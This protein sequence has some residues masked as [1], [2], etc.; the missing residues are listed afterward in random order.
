M[1]ALVLTVGVGRDVER[2]LAHSIRETN[3]EIVVFIHSSDSLFKVRACEELL[4]REHPS[5]WEKIK[6]KIEYHEVN[7]TSITSAID[8]VTG[9]IDALLSRGLSRDDI[10]LDYTTGTKAMSGALT[11]V[12]ILKRIDSVVYVDGD[13][14]ENGRV[15]TG[16]ERLSHERLLE[17]FVRED[18]KR[19]VRSFNSW[20]FDEAKSLLEGVKDAVRKPEIQSE[21]RTLLGLS[22]FYKRCDLFDLKGAL[23]SVGGGTID[24]EIVKRYGVLKRLDDN[25]GLLKALDDGRNGEGEHFANEPPLEY[26]AL[27]YENALRR[28]EEGKYDD[29]VARLY[30]TVEFISQYRLRK[31]GLESS[32]ID[33][34]RALALGEERGRREQVE[35]VCKEQGIEAKRKVGLRGGFALLL[36][37]GDELGAAFDEDERL[38]KLIEAR[39]NSILAHG[40]TAVK[41]E[42]AEELSER[43]LGLLER[44]FKDEGKSLK[45]SR[46]MARFPRLG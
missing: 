32:D 40:F 34:Q 30:R 35:G 29:C 4:Q 41:K 18:I 21:I 12:S 13:R 44:L 16:T 15:I 7:A 22:E 14:D 8:T 10:S 23:A 46:Q 36:A 20:R 38:K 9:V 2:A 6:D 28:L 26:G 39:N 42:V 1:R 11:I 31:Y 5:L 33:I 25:I 45:R 37:L 43:T 24:R 3:P 19:A 27:I 17:L